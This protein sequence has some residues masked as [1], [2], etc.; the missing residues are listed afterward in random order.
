[1]Q[2][3][4]LDRIGHEA[5]RRVLEAKPVAEFVGR[6]ASRVPQAPA[7]IDDSGRSVAPSLVVHVVTAD[8]P[9]DAHDRRR[10]HVAGRSV[11]YD[12]LALSACTLTDPLPARLDRIPLLERERCVPVPRLVELTSRQQC[13]N[14]DSSP[15][16]H[17]PIVAAPR[18]RVK[19]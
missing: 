12:G 16:S 18:P 4:S 15:G 5:F 8:R 10:A 6:Y 2:V 17:S 3:V 1:M 14:R 13:P 7:Q 11:P 19:G 9:D